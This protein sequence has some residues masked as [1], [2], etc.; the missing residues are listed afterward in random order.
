L[1]VFVSDSLKP[2]KLLNGVGDLCEAADFFLKHRPKAQPTISVES[3]VAEFIE[4]RKIEEVGQIYLRDLRLRLG[5]FADHFRCPL[6][7]VSRHD[8]DKY[9]DSLPVRKRTRYNHRGTIGTL[10]NWAKEKG[11]LP[12]DYPSLKKLGK[13]A[14]FALKVLVFSPDEMSKLLLGASTEQAVP[15]ALTSFAG[16]RAEEVKRLAWT[17]INLAKGRVE[18]PGPKAKTGIRRLVPIHDNLR[19]WLE[20]CPCKEGPVCAFSNLANQYLKLA[21]KVGVKWQRNA[22]RHGYV[23]YRVAEIMDLGKVAIEAGHTVGQLQT[24]Y[25]EVVDGEAAKSWFSIFPPGCA[26]ARQDRDTAVAQTTTPP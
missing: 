18:V 24:D 1:D 10:V 11:Y 22:L 15:L 2:L 9:V 25:L 12:S 3:T 17:H 14:R 6:S 7:L 20:R 23:S 8:I 4:S 16:V 19:A 26:N 5:R 21:A 13:R